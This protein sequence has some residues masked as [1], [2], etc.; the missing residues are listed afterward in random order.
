MPV[1]RKLTYHPASSDRWDDVE[2]L[3]GPR[4]A[5][6]GCWCMAWRLKR[7]EFEAGKGASNRKAL[8]TIVERDEQPGVIAY[9]GAEPVGWCAV[10]P[11]SCYVTLERSR[12][13]APVD[14]K[15]VWSISC[16]FVKK[17]HRRAGVSVGLLK[18]AVKLAREK[19]AI[20]VEGYPV[21]PKSG[22]MPDTF[23]WT[24][25]LRSFERAGFMEVL[26][27][28]EAR[29]IMRIEWKSPKA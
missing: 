6:G 2:K 13:L 19:G 21:V 4:G 8:K 10:A 22:A 12:V 18:A 16:L 29:P 25:L 7:S 27:R 20:A 26:R 9:D 3:F 11:R 28:S 17:S 15:P 1:A 24:G 23:A 5:C 14:D